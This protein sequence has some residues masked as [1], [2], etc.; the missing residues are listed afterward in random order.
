M[1]TPATSS[2]TCPIPSGGRVFTTFPEILMLGEFVFGGLVWILVA[3]SKVVFP[4]DEG[5]VMFVSVFCFVITT[6]LF[7]LYM[8]GVQ[9][10]SVNGWLRVDVFYHFFAA[11]FYLSAAV[12]E[13]SNTRH[14]LIA[15]APKIYKLN[16]S[17][18]VFAYLATL[19]YTVHAM[20]SII[21]WKSS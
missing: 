12:L 16:I 20:G 15:L 18:T 13:T 19:L 1:S 5:W 21:R 2:V 7:I 14:L 11:V 10:R 8:A 6:L 3:S 9:K 4:D 17:A